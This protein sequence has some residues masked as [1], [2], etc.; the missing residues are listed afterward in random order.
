MKLKKQKSNVSNDGKLV[1]MKKKAQTI[2]CD[3][4]DKLF[5]P[6]RSYFILF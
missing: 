4:M 2:P 1:N 6:S 3:G 5:H